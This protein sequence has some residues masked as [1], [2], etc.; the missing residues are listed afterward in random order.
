MTTPDPFDPFDLASVVFDGEADER[1]QHLVDED[2]HLRAERETYRALR[3]EMR[4]GVPPNE[5]LDAIRASVLDRFA[6]TASPQR[7][8][9]MAPPT[10][11]PVVELRTRRRSQ[12]VL[13]AAAIVVVV[14]G[15]S[16]AL[17][18][19][20]GRASESATKAASPTAH[21]ANEGGDRTADADAATSTGSVAA[22]S[23]ASA[24]SGG[25]ASGS[26]GA[27]S[28]TDQTLG[29][30]ESDLGATTTL[31]QLAAL[32]RAYQSHNARAATP[33]SLPENKTPA[34]CAA[35]SARAVLNGRVVVLVGTS[36]GVAVLD[37]ATC[38]SIGEF[39][40]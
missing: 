22:S 32:Y 11:A 24:L 30:T 10:T 6:T 29:G 25:A 4:S 33:L 1:E 37:A 5:L 26:A 18:Q 14:A 19:T 38:T 21:V 13:A 8:L 3:D 15:A 36:A 35:P 17:T 27:S 7:D 39:V 20:R 34:S 2:V 23:G 28:P 40:P 31:D 12:Q 16:W 9:T